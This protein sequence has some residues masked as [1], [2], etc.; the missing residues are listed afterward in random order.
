MRTLHLV[1][2]LSAGIIFVVLGLSGSL[3]VFRA[4]I[5]QSEVPVVENIDLDTETLDSDEIRAKLSK[6]YNNF[7]LRSVLLPRR[8]Q[9]PY[10]F[11]FRRE[12][13]GTRQLEKLY[14]DPATGAAKP[15]DQHKSKLEAWLYQLHA[16]LFF[17]S[18][19][20]Q[21]VGY[22]GLFSLVLIALGLMVWWRSVR[23]S[24]LRGL[25]RSLWIPRR[26]KGNALLSS[27]HKVSGL[28]L[29]PLLM[30]L[31]LT[32][33]MLVFRENLIDPLEVS[34]EASRSAGGLAENQGNATSRTCVRRAGLEEYIYAAESAFPQAIASFIKLPRRAGRP[35]EIT[36]RHSNEIS[37][38]LGLTK[39]MLD[40]SCGQ[41]LKVLDGRDLAL[42]QVFTEIVVALHNGAYFGPIGRVLYL[43]L[44]L[45][46][47]FFFVTG[48]VFW[49][50]KKRRKAAISRVT[51]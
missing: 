18:W 51:P 47:M 13:N 44:G 9:D 20:N 32:G 19:G 6:Q 29:S 12:A 35:V 1:L 49:V 27:L 38:P 36:L 33:A 30:L 34:R 26:A 28:Y 42:S 45:V 39:V 10:V 24:G 48:T 11:L 37:S 50:R 25:K 23:G 5:R 14:V 16:N 17:K 4:E 2:A 21:L 43:A 15:F 7:E 8:I 46:P 41:V 22:S 31:A 3:L 40:P